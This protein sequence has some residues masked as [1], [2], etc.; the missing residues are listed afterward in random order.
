MNNIQMI[1]RMLRVKF[2]EA[3]MSKQQMEVYEKIMSSY[4]E[5]RDTKRIFTISVTVPAGVSKKNAK[6]ALK[7]V[8][9]EL[10]PS[11]KLS[12]TWDKGSS[13]NNKPS[14]KPPHI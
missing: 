14:K 3:T 2:H 11:S 6:K 9:L 10:S 8:R 1:Y 5:A 13:N 12:I 7:Q 4:K